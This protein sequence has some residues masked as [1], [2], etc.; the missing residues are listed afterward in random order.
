MPKVKAQ[1]GGKQKEPH[2]SS[3]QRCWDASRSCRSRSCRN[4]VKVTKTGKT[5]K[6]PGLEINEVFGDS[7]QSLYFPP[8]QK[9]LQSGKFL[10]EF[11]VTEF[12]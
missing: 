8:Y 11:T 4:K 9:Y 6:Q 7:G 10:L 12:D 1:G 3:G 5:P 2:L